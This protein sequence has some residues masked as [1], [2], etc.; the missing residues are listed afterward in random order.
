[1]KRPPTN[2]LEEELLE[3][4]GGI[5]RFN[6]ETLLWFAGLF[7]FQSKVGHHWEHNIGDDDISSTTTTLL[8]NPR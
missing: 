5:R 1:V 8:D 6:F 7:L 2:I 3:D 4:C